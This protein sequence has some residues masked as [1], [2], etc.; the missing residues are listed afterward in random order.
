MHYINCDAGPSGTDMHI[1]L[2]SALANLH[3]FTTALLFSNHSVELTVYF[4]NIS[5]VFIIQSKNAERTSKIIIIKMLVSCNTN[6][7]VKRING[8]ISSFFPT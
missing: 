8:N 5:S 1:N 7:E 2:M 3:R 4:N 6:I